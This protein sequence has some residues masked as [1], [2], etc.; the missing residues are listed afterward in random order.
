VAGGEALGEGSVLV[1]DW[2]LDKW[3]MEGSEEER[4]AAFQQAVTELS[5]VLWEVLLRLH[6]RRAE[7]R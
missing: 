2:A 4:K 6:E 3:A 7:G 1:L 5:A